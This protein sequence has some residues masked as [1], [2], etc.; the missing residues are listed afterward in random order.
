MAKVVELGA[1]TRPPTLAELMADPGEIDLWCEECQHR[2]MMPVA[3]LLARHAA[4]TPFPEVRGGFRCSACGSKRVDVRPNWAAQ[5]VAG[6][7]SR[8]WLLDRLRRERTRPWW[9]RMWEGW[10]SRL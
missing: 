6:Q 8:P 2:A 9:R 10:K 7:I 4:D 3:A 1:M 5:R